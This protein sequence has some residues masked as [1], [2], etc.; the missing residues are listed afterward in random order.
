MW[1]RTTNTDSA[2]EPV[3]EFLRHPVLDDDIEF[4]ANGK[5]QVTRAVGEQAIDHYP[6]VEAVEDDEADGKASSSDG[7]AEKPTETMVSTDDE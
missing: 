6:S 5:A 7:E 2:G 1:I 3:T 4:T